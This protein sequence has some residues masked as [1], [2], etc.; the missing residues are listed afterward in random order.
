MLMMAEGGSA[1]S[2]VSVHHVGVTLATMATDAR[3]M[4]TREDIRETLAR[5]TGN[6]QENGV[7]RPPLRRQRRPAA[8]PQRR[9]MARIAA[10]RRDQGNKTRIR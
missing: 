2:A 5:S 7:R 9:G 10:Y 3:S 8:A 1:S 6:T 4:E